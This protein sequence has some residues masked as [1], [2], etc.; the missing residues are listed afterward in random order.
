MLC[1]KCGIEL[2]PEAR[3]CPKCGMKVDLVHMDTTAIPSSVLEAVLS[4]TKKDAPD[5]TENSF[6]LQPAKEQQK[7]EKTDSLQEEC[8]EIYNRKI[9]TDIV[10][11]PTIVKEK[12]EETPTVKF[13]D[14]FH[15]WK[16]SPSFLFVTIIAILYYMFHIV[17]SIFSFNTETMIASFA[18]IILYLIPGSVVLFCT[19]RAIFTKADI[20]YTFNTE[21]IAIKILCIINLVYTSALVIVTITEMICFAMGHN[22]VSSYI[23]W[24]L[25]GDFGYFLINV[26]ISAVS[27]PDYITVSTSIILP[28][29]ALVLSMLYNTSL[30]TLTNSIKKAFASRSVIKLKGPD[31]FA[32]TSVLIAFAYIISATV[33]LVLGNNMLL[34]AISRYLGSLFHISMAF[35]MI[36]LTT[37]S[38]NITAIKE[39]TI[40][41][42]ETVSS[43]NLEKLLETGEIKKIH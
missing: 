42:E 33:M 12:K 17:T 41:E 24:A 9:N 32:H 39:S 22:G 14:I 10:P 27:S 37:L 30:Y 23:I 26:I 11:T 15:L 6:G 18:D 7:E 19:F 1:N 31:A 40:E 38:K 8:F 21:I 29:A 34:Q 3:F 16:K 28:L 5:I 20:P 13:Q 43:V 2:S 36:R 35:L 25:F 4:E